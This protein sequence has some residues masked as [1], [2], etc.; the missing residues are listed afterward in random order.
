MNIR[1]IL[2]QK[3]ARCQKIRNELEFSHSWISKESINGDWINGLEDDLLKKERVSAFC[4]RFGKLQ[5]Y[6]SDKLLKTWV[7]AVG[8][9]VGTAIE[10]FSVAERAGILTIRSEE[11]LGLRKLRND[12]I[13]EYIEDQDLFAEKLNEAVESAEG[14]FKMLDNLVLYS[15]KHL[16]VD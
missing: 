11:I 15:H 8:E 13:H 4:S 14:L 6:F 3:I 10:N 16:G 2:V 9:N 12:L 7:E 5:D 1:E